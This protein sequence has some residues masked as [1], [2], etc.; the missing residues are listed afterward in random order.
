MAAKQASAAKEVLRQPGCEN[1]P[2]ARRMSV[3]WH[4]NVASP[5]STSGSWRRSSPSQVALATSV[6]AHTHNLAEGRWYASCSKTVGSEAWPEYVDCHE[7]PVPEFVPAKFCQLLYRRGPGGVLVVGDSLSDLFAATLVTML[8]DKAGPE[9]ASNRS[10]AV[11]PI[12]SNRTLE[13]VRN[14]PLDTAPA[15]AGENTGRG[16]HCGPK[17]H[18]IFNLHCNPWVDRVAASAIVVL[19]TGTHAGFGGSTRITLA[20][21]REMMRRTAGRTR[22]LAQLAD[23]P[24]RLFYRTSPAGHPGCSSRSRPFASA[25]EANASLL[26]ASRTY[27]W[28]E[29]E[30]RNAL[31]RQTFRPLGFTLLDVEVPTSM[32]PDRHQVDCLH[33]CLPGPSMLWVQLMYAALLGE[34]A[35]MDKPVPADQPSVSEASGAAPDPGRVVRPPGWGWGWG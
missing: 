34:H 14:D 5:C 7:N 33:Y 24:P 31:A 6:A 26:N 19:N 15:Y 30:Q 11:W 9:A 21:F 10:H 28:A 22:E 16:Y 17:Y 8:A 29:Y 4:R 20:M 23:F 35:A 27:D 13:F 18:G 2:S 12:C 32:R 3:A 1:L 25:A